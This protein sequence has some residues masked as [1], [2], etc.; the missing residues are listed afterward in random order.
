MFKYIRPQWKKQIKKNKVMFYFIIGVKKKSN[1]T[2]INAF[3]K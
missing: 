2:L 1:Q 3:H